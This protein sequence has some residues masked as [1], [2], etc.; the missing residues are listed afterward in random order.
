MYCLNFVTH[1]GP[2]CNLDV[3]NA[4]AVAC[5]QIPLAADTVLLYLLNAGPDATAS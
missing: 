3:K 5:G 4:C 2:T 1:V